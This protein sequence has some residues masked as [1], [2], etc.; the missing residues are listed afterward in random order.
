MC[1]NGA[2]VPRRPIPCSE[3]QSTQAIIVILEQLFVTPPALSILDLWASSLV[4]EGSTPVVAPWRNEIGQRIVNSA[5]KFILDD[6]NGTL[7]SIE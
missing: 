1:L 2:A 5:L 3:L 4:E 7:F 6:P